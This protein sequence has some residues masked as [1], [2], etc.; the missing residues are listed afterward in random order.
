MDRWAHLDKR[1]EGRGFIDRL[2]CLP[3]E[4]HGRG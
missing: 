2:V 4:T 1:I 3:V